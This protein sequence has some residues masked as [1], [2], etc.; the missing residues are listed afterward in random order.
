MVF[1]MILKLGY[2]LRH[3][4]T[5]LSACIISTIFFSIVVWFVASKQTVEKDITI[6]YIKIMDVP[7]LII[8]FL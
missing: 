2:L 7:Y 6:D 1:T 5:F 8:L 4:F 3:S